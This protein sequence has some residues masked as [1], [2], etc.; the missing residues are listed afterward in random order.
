M[1]GWSRERRKRLGSL[2][3]HSALVEMKG[4][5]ALCSVLVR[6]EREPCFMLGSSKK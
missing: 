6:N 2:A 1:V 5:L 3:I 4:N